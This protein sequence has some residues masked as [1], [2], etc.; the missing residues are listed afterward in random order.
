MRRADFDRH[1]FCAF[2]GPQ[3]VA[4]TL[5]AEHARAVAKV[6]RRKPLIWVRQTFTFFYTFDVGLQDNLHAN[7]YSPQRVF[8]GPF[9]DRDVELKHECAG[10]LL[11]PN[12][13]YEA[14]FVPF[15]TMSGILVL[16]QKQN[17]GLSKNAKYSMG[18][19]RDER[20][21][22]NGKLAE[23]ARRRGRSDK[24]R[25]RRQILA[26]RLNKTQSLQTG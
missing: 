11:N 21:R 6:L 9:K 5:T 17:S 16:N 8:L 10:V 18:G 19:E 3:V 15:Y 13:R 12:C 22:R 7:D 4:P 2:A 20:S 25:E 24:Q 14:N 23:R 1:E 26:E